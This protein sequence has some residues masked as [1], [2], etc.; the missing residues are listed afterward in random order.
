VYSVHIYE[1]VNDYKEI[2]ELSDIIT[3]AD[4]YEHDGE[5]IVIGLDRERFMEHMREFRNE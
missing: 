5:R 2:E 4:D 3:N 1:E